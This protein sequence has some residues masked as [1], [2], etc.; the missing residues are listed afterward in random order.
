MLSYTSLRRALPSARLLALGIVA[1]GS[2]LGAQTLHG[3]QATTPVTVQYAVSGPVAAVAG[4]TVTYT[5]NV[6]N[7][8]SQDATGLALS[9][10]GQNTAT[11]DGFTAGAGISCNP[12]AVNQMVGIDCSL[13]SL[14]AGSTTTITV[15]VTL[16]NASAPTYRVLGYAG[17]PLC[18]CLI[19]YFETA[20]SPAPN[21]TGAS[22]TPSQPQPYSPPPPYSGNGF[23]PN[24]GPHGGA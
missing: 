2:L 15:R 20:V 7:P 6:R 9:L 17:P 10:L 11:V 1:T 14:A 13:A 23:D 16:S 19:P 4:D 18:R 8:N 22:T 24:A 12:I 3:A 21:S 5:L